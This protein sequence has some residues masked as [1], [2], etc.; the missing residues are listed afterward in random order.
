MGISTLKDFTKGYAASF[1]ER[2]SS[3]LKGLC[4]RELKKKKIQNMC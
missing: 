3:M 4:D 1:P 2:E